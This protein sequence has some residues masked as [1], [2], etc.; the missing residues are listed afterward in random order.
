MVNR[1]QRKAIGAKCPDGLGKGLT[2]E[3]KKVMRI[4][5]NVCKG[6]DSF[7]SL[8]YAADHPARFTRRFI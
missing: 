8:A 3:L 1:D 5:G 7:R 4:S 6:Y 2:V